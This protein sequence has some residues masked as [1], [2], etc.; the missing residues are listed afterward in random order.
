MSEPTKKK[1]IFDAINAV[2]GVRPLTYQDMLSEG[3][4]YEPFMVNR[5]FSLSEDAVRAAALMNERPHLDKDMQA[6]F[7][8]HTL[9]PRRRFEKWPKA[10]TDD[11]VSVIAQYYGMSQRE[12]KLYANLHTTEQYAEMREVLADGAQ[13]SRYR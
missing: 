10:L 11:D 1:T 6:T 5:A 9:R 3:L 8:I 13:P 7:Y 4:P 2:S 12:A